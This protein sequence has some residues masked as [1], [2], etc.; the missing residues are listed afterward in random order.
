M[1]QRGNGIRLL[2]ARGNKE[3]GDLLTIPKDGELEAW[4]LSRPDDSM[5]LAHRIF[6][7]GQGASLAKFETWTIHSR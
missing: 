3:A 6:T 1:N 7:P 4:H 2:G 5:A